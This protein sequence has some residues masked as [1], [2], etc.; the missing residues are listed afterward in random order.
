MKNRLPYS[1]ILV[2]QQP[3]VMQF[4]ILGRSWVSSLPRR[5]V[6]Q[7]L[8]IRQ[9]AEAM[10]VLRRMTGILPVFSVLPAVFRYVVVIVSAGMRVFFRPG[11]SA[12]LPG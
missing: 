8:G 1:V 9:A 3:R 2:C 10:K 11:E 5:Y 12:I 6:P 7:R 4:C